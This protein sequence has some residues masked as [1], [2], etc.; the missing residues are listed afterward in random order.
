MRQNIDAR[1]EKLREAI[2]DA[3]SMPMSASA[4]VNRA[5]LLELVDAV[6]GALEETL[7]R[8]D[9]VLGDRDTVVSQGRSDAEEIRRQAQ[10]DHD[11]LVSDTEVYKVA[12]VRAEELHTRTERECA[13]LRAET[14]EYVEQ[15]LANFELTLE[16]TLDAV[17][18]GRARLSGGH[19]HALGDDSDVAG[20]SLP[21]HLRRD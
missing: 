2:K 20:M 21:E 9:E 15:S 4:V 10:A 5:E 14:D 18:R 17:K 13:E 11:K 16:R 1:L 7:S 6:Q 19:V 3:R 8:A 12:Q